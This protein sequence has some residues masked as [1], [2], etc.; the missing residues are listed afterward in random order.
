[1][2]LLPA[3][4]NSVKLSNNEIFSVLTNKGQFKADKYVVSLG[5][6]SKKILSNI[7]IE[8]PVYPVKG[9]SIT[10]PVLSDNDAPQSTIMDEKNKIAI[11][12]LGDKIRVAGMAHLTDFNK[13]L[14]EKSRE[15]LVS[16][17]DLIFP[18]GYKSSNNVNFWTGFR[19]S[20]PDGTPIIG[21]TPYKNLYLNTGHGTLGWTMSAG[22]GKLLSNLISGIDPEISTEG[23]DMSRY[24]FS[25]KTE[26]NY[27]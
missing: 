19:P 14:R 8:I 25:N 20:T 9:Y 11:T 4:I 17:L 2:T 1:M 16:G 12:R 5:S 18:K 23:I 24:S 10:M 27:G 26:F 13:H 7:G 6:Y 3:E 21:N 22:S 15:S